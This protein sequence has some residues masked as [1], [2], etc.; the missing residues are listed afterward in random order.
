MAA[1]A[2]PYL[3]DSEQDEILRSTNSDAAD[4]AITAN[5]P[6]G[7]YYALVDRSSGDTNYNFSLSASPLTYSP[8]NL[9]GNTE[10]QTKNIGA[11]GAAQ[12]FTDFVGSQHSIE[13]DKNDYYQFTLAED[14]TVSLGLGGLSANA[15]LT[16]R[17]SAGSRIGTSSNFATVA[18]A[19]TDNLVVD[20][21]QR[22][23]GEHRGCQH[24]L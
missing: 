10:A 7:T 2:N 11:L 17:N 15:D 9:V 3:Y 24:R 8:A 6:T 20:S 23:S 4:D 19:I 5:L 18:E 12:T 1:N 22:R 16:L 13:S 21:L 14:A